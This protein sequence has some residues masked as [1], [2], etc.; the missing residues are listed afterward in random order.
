MA[1]GEG[2]GVKIPYVDGRLQ[3]KTKRSIGQVNAIIDAYHDA[4][5]GALSVRQ[6][7][8]QMITRFGLPNRNS[9]YIKVQRLCAVGRLHGY[10][11]WEAIE[12]RVRGLESRLHLDGPQEALAKIA[13]AYGIDLWAKQDQ[14]IE[15]WFEK[16][17]LSGIFARACQDLDIS[18]LA[19]C[20]YPSLSVVHDAALRIR[21]AIAAG[22]ETHIL[23]FTD[24][25]PA[26][27]N[28]EFSLRENMETFRC[29]VKIERIALTMEQIRSMDLPPNQIDP[30][31]GKN[32]L[33]KYEK[34]TGTRLMW[35]LDAVPP[36]V[37][38]R[39]VR[40]ESIWAS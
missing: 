36:D 22:K 40:D 15:V 5:F 26:G 23:Y 12:D 18:Y 3:D 37:L 32:L 10:I 30:D 38:V 16:E 13:R 17:A 11:D 19:C 6:V 39:M 31:K 24:H 8:Y 25:D 21:R 7:H 9:T 33:P 27:L 2:A 4:G 34:S 14:H 29:P 28:M 35:E 20:G 1:R